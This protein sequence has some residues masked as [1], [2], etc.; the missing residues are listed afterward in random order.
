M[1]A[2]EIYASLGI[3]WAFFRFIKAAKMVVNDFEV[4]SSIT[5]EKEIERKKDARKRLL[6][7]DIIHNN[8][9]LSSFI[10]SFAL[11]FLSAFQGLIWPLSV[12]SY[13]SMRLPK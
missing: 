4:D 13:I 3:A 11:L 1:T 6:E 2:L 12:I 7:I 5:C 9:M 8:K 10:V